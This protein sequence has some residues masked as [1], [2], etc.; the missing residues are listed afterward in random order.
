MLD[1]FVRGLYHFVSSG[2]VGWLV[3]RST[4]SMSS[5]SWSTGLTGS[6]SSISWSRLRLALLSAVWTHIIADMVEHGYPPK[7]HEGIAGFGRWLIDLL[8]TLG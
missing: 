5:G 3:W 7:L 8:A 1:L 2:F 6:T 4:G